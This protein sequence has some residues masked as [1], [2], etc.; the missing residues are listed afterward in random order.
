MNTEILSRHRLPTRYRIAL[1]ILWCLP[2]CLM[3][4]ALLL[5]HG[6]TWRL[7]HPALLM[8]ACVMLVPAVYVWHEGIDITRRGVI[9]R[10][11][12]WR[13]HAFSQLAAWGIE[14]RAGQRLL[15]IW[16]C[17]GNCVFESHTHH[18]THV[19][20]LTDVLRCHLRRRS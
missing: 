9:V 1:V 18:L 11:H 2:I 7:L 15:S 16:D 19:S 17:K 12:A 8:P 5:S 10:T 4:S 14:R 6:P 3:W 13:Y 20:Q